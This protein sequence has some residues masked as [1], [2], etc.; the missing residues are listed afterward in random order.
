MEIA[1]RG[2]NVAWDITEPGGGMKRA[3]V[4]SRPMEGVR[5]T[6]VSYIID[7]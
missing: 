1:S 4:R 5:S 2:K 7:C 3:G 6:F